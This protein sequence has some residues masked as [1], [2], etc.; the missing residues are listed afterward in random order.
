[1]AAEMSYKKEYTGLQYTGE[2]R[3]EAQL[4]TSNIDEVLHRCLYSVWTMIN[5]RQ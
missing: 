5:K 4:S 2:T 1:M 3:P